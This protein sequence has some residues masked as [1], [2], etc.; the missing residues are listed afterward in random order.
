MRRARICAR[1]PG[2]ISH[3]GACPSGGCDAQPDH[4]QHAWPVPSG[5][6]LTPRAST[7]REAASRSR[8]RCDR[9]DLKAASSTF[10]ETRVAVLSEERAR[11][12]MTHLS[13]HHQYRSRPIPQGCLGSACCDHADLRIA[14]DHSLGQ[15]VPG[16]DSNGPAPLPDRGSFVMPRTLPPHR[17]GIAATAGRPPSDPAPTAR[18]ASAADE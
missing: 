14:L 1:S 18:R 10:H 2:E 6:R 4:D 9:T 5:W 12:P 11:P 13:L 7:T 15:R 8:S 16:S 3:E 17:G